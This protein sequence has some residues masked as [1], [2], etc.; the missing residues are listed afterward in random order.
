MTARQYKRERRWRGTSREVAAALDVHPYTI[1]KRENGTLAVNREAA[2]ALLTLPRLER[3]APT[4]KRGR[5]RLK[6]S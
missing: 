6:N 1:D 4:P 5:P 3:L 2:L